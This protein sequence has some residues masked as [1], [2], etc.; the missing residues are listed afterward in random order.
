[1]F[2]TGEK[3]YLDLIAYMT[4]KKFEPIL[5]IPG[6]FNHREAREMQM[7]GVFVRQDLFAKTHSRPK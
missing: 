4:E 3:T 6:Y 2:Y 1:M 5:F 7:D